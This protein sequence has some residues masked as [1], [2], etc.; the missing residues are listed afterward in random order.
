[1]EVGRRVAA[2]ETHELRRRVLRA[3]DPDASVVFDGDDDAGT[4]HLGVRDAAGTLVAVS[5]WRPPP[6]PVDPAPTDRQLRGMAVDDGLRGSGLGA[7][8]LA[9]GVQRAFD[10]G[11]G[12]VWANARD[13]ALAFYAPPRVRGRRRRLR[14][15]RHRPPAPP[16]PPHAGLTP[17]RTP[18]DIVSSVSRHAAAP[19]FTLD[20]MIPHR[21]GRL[22]AGTPIAL[23]SLGLAACGSD[24][25]DSAPAARP[26]RHRTGDRVAA[27][28]PAP[29]GDHRAPT[30]PAHRSPGRGGPDIAVGAVDYA[31]EDLPATMPAG[32]VLSLTNHSTVELHEIVAFRLPDTETSSVDE[33]MALPEAD[34]EAAIADR[35]A[36]P[37]HAGPARAAGLLRPRRR[38]AREPGR[39]VLLCGIPIGADPRRT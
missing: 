18:A 33:L 24:D 13:T 4:V 30:P 27:P 10:D 9:A 3:G 36:G 23:A 21:H 32:T 38:H 25:D 28:T 7:V 17:R 8:L 2:G 34:L 39:Y 31:F 6:G 12:A 15:R 5:T 37:R 20:A 35:S 14:R 11:A 16:H 1:M 22:L 19:S 26:R 29:A